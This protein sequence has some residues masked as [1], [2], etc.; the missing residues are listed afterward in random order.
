VNCNAQSADLKFT[1]ITPKENQHLKIENKP[2]LC[3]GK[4]QCTSAD[5]KLADIHVWLFLMDDQLDGYYIQKAV[6]LEQDGTWSGSIKPG[7]SIIKIVAV[8]ADKTA[9]TTFKTWIKNQEYGKHD[10]LPDGATIIASR[11]IK[12]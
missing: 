9:N 1:F 7:P 6:I 8:L 3:N 11:K 5:T 4:Y 12:T 10:E 2:F